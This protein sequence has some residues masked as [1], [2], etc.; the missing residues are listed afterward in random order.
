MNNPDIIFIGAGPVGLFTAIQA[1]LHNPT[2]NIKM[3]ER[4]ETYTRG[5]MLKINPASYQDMHPDPRLKKITDQL[6]GSVPTTDIEKQLRDLAIELRIDIQRGQLIEDVRRLARD[7]P[8]AHTIVGSDG[9]RSGVRKQI[10][11]DRKSVDE[12]TQTIVEVKYQVDADA[13]R[14]NKYQYVEGLTQIPH[15]VAEN[16]GRNKDGK[17]PVS[18]FF[19]A[20][21]QTGDEIRALGNARDPARLVDIKAGTNR[22]T[23][24]AN[25]IRPWLAL[26]ASNGEK[27]VPGSEKITAVDLNVYQSEHFVHLDNNVRY[28]LI[29]DAAM[30]VPYFRAL[31]AGLIGGSKAA[32][33]IANTGASNQQHNAHFE[34]QMHALARKEIQNAFWKNQGVNAGRFYRG[35]INT[36]NRASAFD[37]MPEKSRMA[38]QDARVTPASFYR[39]HSRKL[40][41]LAIFAVVTGILIGTGGVGIASI[42]GALIAGAVTAI[43]AVAVYKLVTYIIRK[44][45]SSPNNLVQE[46]TEQH[47]D[48]APEFSH[49]VEN[50]ND[51]VNSSSDEPYFHAPI[52]G[53]PT[54]S[55]QNDVIVHPDAPASSS[56]A[57]SHQEFHGTSAPGGSGP[58]SH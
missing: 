42:I 21:K 53:M 12:T 25:S 49:P 27:R 55:W 29:G 52:P 9:A 54:L 26:R 8:S 41:V 33:L 11:A 36:I 13:P 23:D 40:L 51:L 35:L 39:R 50:D 2:L 32:R 45:R 56:N 58:H 48:H 46:E 18:L 37:T 1:K 57:P 6:V 4:N 43:A 31:N 24:L 16:V 7:Y 28:V 38:M 47:A 17:T 15:F 5:H 19:F 14:L 22:M 3:F 20:D 34:Q 44:A 30:G 10:F